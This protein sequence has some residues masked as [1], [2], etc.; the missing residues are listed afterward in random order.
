VK[1]IK[2][3]IITAAIGISCLLSFFVIFYA[4]ITFRN[5]TYSN[6]LEDQASFMFSA[7]LSVESKITEVIHPLE[8]L[9]NLI[10]TTPPTQTAPETINDYKLWQL[11][12]SPYVTT[13]FHLASPNET[14]ELYFFNAQNQVN[15]QYLSFKDTNQDDYLDKPTIESS[16][17]TTG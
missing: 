15:S 16:V 10:K 7:V 11:A 3:R 6:A 14:L 13:Q 5:L 17:L 2:I 12:L 8:H 9:T 4:Q 1:S